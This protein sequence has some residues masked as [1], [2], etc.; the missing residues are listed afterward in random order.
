MAE[1]RNAR[2]K[3]KARLTPTAHASITTRAGDSATSLEVDILILDY[4]AYNTTR[5]C[6]A[7][8]HA[9]STD[10]PFHLAHN[11]SLF[12]TFLALFKHNHPNHELDPELRFRILLSQLI[13]LYTQRLTRNPSTPSRAALIVLR[14]A[15]QQRARDWIAEP[16]RVPSNGF[17]TT[18][19]DNP[20]SGPSR[21]HLERNRAHI[22]HALGIPAEDEA[23]ED[24]YYGTPL[25]V[26]LLDLLPL[27]VRVSAARNALSE[28][29]LTG[30][31]MRMAGS[32]MLQGAL[33]QYLG[34]GARGT[35]GVEEAFAWGLKARETRGAGGEVGEGG[36]DKEEEGV[37]VD[38]VEE[39]FTDPVSEREVE[40]WAALK[41]EYLSELLPPLDDGRPLPDTSA[42]GVNG[43]PTD[44]PQLA[45]FEA[46]ATRHPIADFEATILEFLAALSQSVPTPVLTQLEGGELDGMSR[47]ETRDF[48]RNCGLGD[49]G[50]LWVRETELTEELK[51]RG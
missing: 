5:A 35:D 38:E 25:S 47:A 10:P 8:R 44:P 43:T 22:L 50:R 17:D 27:F 45:H 6:L 9:Q 37:Q 51:G 30:L 3:K 26:A 19:L 15:N 46:V 23:Y 18:T 16:S 13:V 28:G 31:W 49:L 21:E 40:G 4:L 39:M 33:E 24:A 20:A 32:F 7:S 11:L 14:A 34:F 12:D 42:D 2:P 48:V 36:E 1:I 41:R 29:Q